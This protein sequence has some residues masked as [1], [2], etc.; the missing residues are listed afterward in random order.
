MR[1]NF[2]LNEPAV[3]RERVKAAGFR[4]TLYYN[5]TLPMPYTTP[6][7]VVEHRLTKFPAVQAALKT[8]DDATARK[9]RDKLLALATQR[10]FDRQHADTFEALVI[11]AYK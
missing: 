5:F 11:I 9:L 4:R 6:E 3:L 8:A 7:E 1:S 10:M 2:H